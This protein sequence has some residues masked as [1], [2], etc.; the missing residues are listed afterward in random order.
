MVSKL[1]GGPGAASGVVDRP[2]RYLYLSPLARPEWSQ[3]TSEA[4]MEEHPPTEGAVQ[5]VSGQPLALSE[6]YWSS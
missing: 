5:A 2:T 1:E 4:P 6:L 3:E